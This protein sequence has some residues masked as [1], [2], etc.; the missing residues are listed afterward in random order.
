MII[1]DL[2]SIITTGRKRV[3]AKVTWEDCNRPEM[4]VFLETVMDF[5]EGLAANPHAFLVGCIMAA[6]YHGEKRILIDAEICPELRDGLVTAMKRFAHW[7]P[8]YPTDAPIVRIEAKKRFSKSLPKTD[9][10]RAMFFS[11]GVDSLATLRNN[12]INFPIGH[13]S[14]ISDGFLVYGLEI[15]KPEKFDIVMKTVP[16]IAKDASLTLIPVYTN[17][18]YLD[19]TWRFW[20]HMLMGSLFSAIAHAFTQ[21]INSVLIASHYDIPYLEKPYGSHPLIDSNYSSS[22]LR[23]KH[24]RPLPRLKKT[25]MISDWDCALENVRV[26]NKTN[27]YE[28]DQINCSECEK[29]L[30]TMMT[31]L[32]CDAL[33]RSTA[34]KYDDVSAEMILSTI[35]LNKTIY[36]FYPELVQPLRDAGRNDLANIIQEK[37]NEYLNPPVP[38]KPLDRRIVE[39]ISKIDKDLLNRSLSKINKAFIN[40]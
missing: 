22:D 15:E 21:R 14:S 23:V 25:K 13:P 2:K 36:S 9:G 12:R 35:K 33:K 1:D 32:T 20:E 4:E 30:R 24:D 26:C 29:C 10:R 18:R 7:Y 5:A 34:F 11:G 3:S 37:L 40:I 27:L 39:I 28:S 38:K 31:L 6:M 17:L 19:D 8:W 16:K